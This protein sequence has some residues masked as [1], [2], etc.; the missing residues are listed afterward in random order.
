[1]AARRRRASR[2]LFPISSRV[3]TRAFIPSVSAE[4][5]ESMRP[6]EAPL[7]GSPERAARA[8]RSLLP[9]CWVP[10][11]K[12]TPARARAPSC[13]SE[14][15]DRN[16]PAATRDSGDSAAFCSTCMS[17]S[18]PAGV[19]AQFSTSPATTRAP[20]LDS[21]GEVSR[22]RTR[23]SSTGFEAKEPRSTVTACAPAGE[24]DASWRKRE[25][26]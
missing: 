19:R 7:S 26:M 22:A 20:S 15:C 6:A 5:L 8:A 2:G 23:E 16:R 9:P 10:G 11:V 3:E 4:I 21:R 12:S 24:R 14:R 25:A 13:D 1:M 18:A 17:P